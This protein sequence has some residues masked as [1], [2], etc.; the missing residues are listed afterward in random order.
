[1]KTLKMSQWSQLHKGSLGKVR[2]IDTRSHNGL[3]LK[4]VTRLEQWK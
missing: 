4:S 2:D 1:M 3:K